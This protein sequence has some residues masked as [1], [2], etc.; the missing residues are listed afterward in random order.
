MGKAH[1]NEIVILCKMSEIFIF[2]NYSLWLKS[3]SENSELLRTELKGRVLFLSFVKCNLSCSMR[4][5][6]LTL[7]KLENIYRRNRKNYNVTHFPRN[8][9]TFDFKVFL[10]FFSSQIFRKYF[11]CLPNMCDVW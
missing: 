1:N 4:H 8:V 3:Y 10:T 6:I 2:R 9:V 11:V 7:I 5:I